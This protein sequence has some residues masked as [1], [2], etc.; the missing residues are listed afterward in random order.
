MCDRREAASQARQGEFVSD[1][2]PDLTTAV[3]FD[4]VSVWRDPDGTVLIQVLT[5]D[6]PQIRIPAAKWEQIVR[7]VAEQAAKEET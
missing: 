3:L 2:L 5:P 1:E 6:A 4:Q 7:F